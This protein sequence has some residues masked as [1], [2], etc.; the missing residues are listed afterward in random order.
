MP[1]STIEIRNGTRQP[2]SLNAASP[3]NCLTPMMTTSERNR[4]S[5]AVVWIHEV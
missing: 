1:S 2:H 3:K 5:V 4:P